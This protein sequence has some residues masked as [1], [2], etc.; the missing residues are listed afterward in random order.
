[1]GNLGSN[2]QK[3]IDNMSKE[4]ANKKCM[5]ILDKRYFVKKLYGEQR[6]ETFKKYT[7]NNANYL[8]TLPSGDRVYVNYVNE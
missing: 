6:S 8:E 2:E 7:I 3:Y 4:C 1:M 5:F